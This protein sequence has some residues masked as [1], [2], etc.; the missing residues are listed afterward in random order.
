M[1]R[2]NPAYFLLLWES[3]WLFGS[4]TTRPVRKKKIMSDQFNAAKNSLADRASSPR[5][6]QV[7]GEPLFRFVSFGDWVG[8]ATQRFQRA[9]VRGKDV[10]CLDAE[11]NICKIGKDF[12][13]ADAAGAFPVTVYRRRE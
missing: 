3:S 9:G 5:P 6:A 12:M 8:H 10:I 4:L 13:A 7:W 1:G 2:V 11:G